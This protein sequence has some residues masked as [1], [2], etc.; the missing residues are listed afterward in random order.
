MF[1]SETVPYVINPD[2]FKDCL[3]QQQLILDRQLRFA[4]EQSVHVARLNSKLFSPGEYVL[5]PVQSAIK[6]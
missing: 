3:A 6:V 5:S 1:E 4:A 2:G